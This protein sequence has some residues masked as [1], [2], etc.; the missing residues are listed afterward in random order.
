MDIFTLESKQE[1]L[2][3]HLTGDFSPRLKLFLLTEFIEQL[4]E[5]D[6]KNIIEAYIAGFLNEYL[7]LL[8]IYEPTGL[9]PSE[10]SR[11]IFPLDKIIEY[12]LFN[13]YRDELL[14]V[15][16]SLNKK[17]NELN[18]SLL[19][20]FNNPSGRLYFPVLEHNINQNGETGF[21]EYVEIKI[22]KSP[23][24]KEDT[25]FI[26]PSGDKIEKRLDEQ[27][28]NSWSAAIQ[29]VKEKSLKINSKHEV[30]ISFKKKYGEY[31]GNSLGLVLTIGFIQELLKL[32][33]TRNIIRIKEG[34]AI[35]GGTDSNG[36]VVPL[37]D[38]IISIKVKVAFFSTIKFL[39]V[40]KSNEDHANKELEKL[41]IKFPG[42][43][44]LIIGVEDL[45][46]VLDRR[47]VADI[48]K[49]SLFIW[50]AKFSRKNWISLSLLAIIFLIVFATGILDFDTNPVHVEFKNDMAYIENKSGKVLW[51]IRMM[52]NANNRLNSGFLRYSIR[53]ADINNDGTNDVFVSDEYFNDTK[54]NNN[55]GRIACFDNHHNL[56][57]KYNFHDTV[58][59][60]TF[61][62]VN[63][64]ICYIIGIIKQKNKK[65]IYAIAR[66]RNL[67]P[68]AIFEL[69]AKTGK[70]ID[71]LN[72]LWNAGGIT[73]GVIGDFNHDGKPELIVTA[74]HNGFQRA[75]LFSIDMNKLGG[76]TPAPPNYTFYNMKAASLNSFILL[77]ISDY[78]RYYFRW[79]MP[80]PASLQYSSVNNQFKFDVDEGVG[81]ISDMA[82]LSY[83]FDNKLNFEFISCDDRFQVQRDSLV[84]KGVL[85]PPYTNTPGYFN[86]LRNQIK[87]WIGNKF[88]S[89]NELKDKNLRKFK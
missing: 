53:F 44:L 49:L 28:K 73:N 4:C 55:F 89:I 13:N 39:V 62:S 51:T 25:F 56:I 40:P 78:G 22:Q 48:R 79:N 18:N 77:P 2:A 87:Y 41:K 5:F 65:V 45:D 36:V 57:W 1:E 47:K 9:E 66:N 10:T 70:R 60:P 23:I 24:R 88:I 33:Q 38:D 58:S 50:A 11:I 16:Q 61:K 19:N 34:I 6:N 82:A 86:S 68:N 43:E 69:D 21:L 71:S 37:P 46:D 7:N 52:D 12:N 85:K 14:F 75:V 64:Y 15:E 59:S 3:S 8:K 83:V 72:T 63:I 76:Q 29:F 54:E 20:N 27:I 42:R 80:A 32:Y 26:I 74:I 35:T 81:N 30:V 84:A 31:V 17:L 67:Y